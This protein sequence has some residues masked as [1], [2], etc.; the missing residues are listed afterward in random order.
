MG[1][2]LL[3]ENEKLEL[4]GAHIRILLFIEIENLEF[5]SLRAILFLL[6]LKRST[7]KK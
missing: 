3:I 5:N 2:M 1:I 6:N 7:N 4:T